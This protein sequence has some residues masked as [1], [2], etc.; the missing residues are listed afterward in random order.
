M[1]IR[2]NIPVIVEAQDNGSPKLAPYCR[3]IRFYGGFEGERL[4]PSM[5]LIDVVHF[6]K[7]I[8]AVDEKVAY[9]NSGHL[10]FL[11]S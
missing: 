5:L 8:G 6:W 10:G 3:I 7:Y 11:Y 4:I 9:Q 1:W 2:T